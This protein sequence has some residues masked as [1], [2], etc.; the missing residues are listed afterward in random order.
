MSEEVNISVKPATMTDLKYITYLA[1]L[2]GRSIGFIPKVAYESAI[3]GS[4][5]SK[6]RWSDTCNDKIFMC[7]ENATENNPDPV[8]FVMMSYGKIAKVNQ[9]CIQEDARLLERG[10]ALLSAATD[11]GM[12]NGIYQFGCGCADDLESNLFWAAMGWDKVGQRKGIHFS[13]TWKESSDRIVNIY[14]YL[15]SGLPFI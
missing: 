7:Y 2:N 14:R 11:H 3:K 9:I 10:K 1:N 4:K 8:G 5:P 6:N 12:K 15:I 13:N